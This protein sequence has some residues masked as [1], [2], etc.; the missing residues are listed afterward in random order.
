MVD[1]ELACLDH[2]CAHLFLFPS[3]PPLVSFYPCSMLPVL[4]DVCT[5]R[6]NPTQSRA[7]LETHDEKLEHQKVGS[8]P[9]LNRTSVVLKLFRPRVRRVT[10]LIR[11]GRGLPL[12]VSWVTLTSD[13]WLPNSLDHLPC[14]TSDTLCG[15][16][17]QAVASSHRLNVFITLRRI[18]PPPWGPPPLPNTQ[19]KRTSSANSRV[20]LMPRRTSAW[21]I[22]GA[23][24]TVRSV[25]TSILRG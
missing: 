10:S 16:T 8:L 5:V 15:K 18:Q 3:A 20:G 6:P 11:K 23:I 19:T 21:V 2:A 13:P 7:L 1:P 12:A 17:R 22:F 9:L 24:S 14:P 25:G 4:R